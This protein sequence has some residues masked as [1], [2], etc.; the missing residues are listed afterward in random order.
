MSH[1]L[2]IILDTLL[3]FIASLILSFCIMRLFNTPPAAAIVCSAVFS[4][5]LSV[6]VF[7]KKQ[8]ASKIKLDA[9]RLS[10][11]KNALSATLEK[12]SDAQLIELLKGIISKLGCE[13]HTT[14]VSTD[15]PSHRF[16]PL[17]LPEGVNANELA[18][19]VRNLPC[20]GKTVCVLSRSFTAD[21]V[22]YAKERSVRLFAIEQIYPLVKKYAPEIIKEDDF[23]NSRMP[24][25]NLLFTKKNGR[26]FILYGILLDIFSLLSFYPVYYVI[27]GTVFIT[28]GLITAFFGTKPLVQTKTLEQTI[29]GED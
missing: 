17:F 13:V 5:T 22:F 9:T 15:T 26:K 10:R 2:P 14:N 23:K 6:A 20:D 21:A 3:S 8:S 7:F 12:M 27:S 16:V 25:F 18:K 4:A 28:T 29:N 19:S 24:K 11:S 1:R